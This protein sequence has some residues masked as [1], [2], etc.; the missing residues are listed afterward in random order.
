MS[1]SSSDPNN[2]AIHTKRHQRENSRAMLISNAGLALS[3]ISIFSSGLLLSQLLKLQQELSTTRESV[4]Q[5][6][7]ALNSVSTN[8][9]SQPSASTSP[10]P[11]SANPEV[12]NQVPESTNPA[13]QP[14]NPEAVNSTES[15][16][17]PETTQSASAPTE[18]KPGEYIQPAFGNKAKVELLQ[19]NR[20][21]DRESDD[22]NI[23]NVQFQVRRVTDRVLGS[24]IIDTTE[25]KARDPDTS[26]VYERK[27]YTY[28]KSLELE[29]LPKDKP[30]KTYVWLSVPTGVTAIDIIIPQTQVFEKVPI[31]DMSTPS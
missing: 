31:K 13:S 1:T 26:E 3:I 20:I 2:S 12:A 21:R 30:V 29:S 24:D 6:V 5:A 19:V 27:P 17:I 9:T 16:T 18:I 10:A 25:I 4:N 15:Q 7:T 11:Q 23:V 14:A 8:P 28:G 22:N